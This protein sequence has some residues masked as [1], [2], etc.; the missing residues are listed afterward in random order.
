MTFLEVAY[1]TLQKMQQP[2]SIH[3]IWENAVAYGFTESLGTA[4]K[5]PIKTLAARIYVDLRDNAA[6]KFKQVSQRPA[7]FT[8]V[9]TPCLER[10]VKTEQVKESKR[11]YNERDLHPLLAAFV[12][13]DSHFKCYTKTIYHEK[14]KKGKKGL[15]GWLHPDL[16]GIF[17]PFTN[18]H[19]STTKLIDSLHENEC[20]LFSFEMKISVSFLNLREAYFQAVSNSSWANEGYLVASEYEDDPELMQEMLRLTNSFG[21]GFIRLDIANVEQSEILVPSKTRSNLDWDTINRLTVTNVDFSGFIETIAK[22]I[23]DK[24]V[25]NTSDYDEVFSNED[26]LRE[27]IISKGF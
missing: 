3:E 21:I 14:S 6:T 10:T 12:Y 17:F 8:L 18:Y 1:K 2:L 7:M 5:T 23:C 22:D 16:V 9:D 11:K 25:R 24:E 26:K 15:T 20:K 4:G 27:Y 13:A 19:Y